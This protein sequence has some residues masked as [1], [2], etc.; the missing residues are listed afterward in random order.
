MEKLKIEEALV[1]ATK[2][3]MVKIDRELFLLKELKERYSKD[4]VEKAI[5]F[6][7]AYAG[8]PVEEIDK[9]AKS[10]IKS[11]T[12]KVTAISAAAGIPGGLEETISCA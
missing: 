8:I 10:Y 4:V 2:L 3:P 6:N 1:Q 7:P 5:E 12:A 11:E 9:I